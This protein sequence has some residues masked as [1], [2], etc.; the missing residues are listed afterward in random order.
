MVLAG[1]IA[2]AA[3]T[4]VQSDVVLYMCAADMGVQPRSAVRFV[5]GVITKTQSTIPLNCPSYAPMEP[6]LIVH[7]G[8]LVALEVHTM[9]RRVSPAMGPSPL[10]MGGHGMS[11]SAGQ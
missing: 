2:S 10:P 5:A 8:L 11:S 3:S 7:P 9:A 4:V 1:V 6:L